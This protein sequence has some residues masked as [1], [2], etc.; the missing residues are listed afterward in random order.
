MSVKLASISQ[1]AESFE[2]Q[3]GTN[4]FTTDKLNEFHMKFKKQATDLVFNKFYD[5]ML[6]LVKL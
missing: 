1:Y 5:Q 3:F 2:K 6:Y 4:H